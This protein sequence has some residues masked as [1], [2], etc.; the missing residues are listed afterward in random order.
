MT[1]IFSKRCEKLLQKKS[2]EE[3]KQGDG[4]LFYG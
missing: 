3:V 4:S 2:I 1:W